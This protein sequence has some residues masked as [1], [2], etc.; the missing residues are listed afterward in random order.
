[1]SAFGHI[2]AVGECVVCPELA[3]ASFAPFRTDSGLRSA[4]FVQAAC[5]ELLVFPLPGQEFVHAFGRL[6]GQS[7]EHVDE[8]SLWTDL[9]EL[10]GR[11]QG[12]DHRG[13]RPPSSEP[14]NVQF[15]RPIATAR[16]SLPASLL[17][18]QSRPSSRKRVSA[19]HSRSPCGLAVG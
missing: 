18:T 9:V 2:A 19:A 17:D 1:M 3:K 16:I 7:R 12:V 15:L 6:V 10:R 4:R 8:R 14:A 13:R 11:N 5:G